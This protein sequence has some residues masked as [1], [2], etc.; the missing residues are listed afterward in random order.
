[1]ADQRDEPESKPPRVWICYAHDPPEHKVQVEEFAK[2]LRQQIGV[3]V[4]L[5][6]WYLEKRL[7][8]AQWAI[9][10]LDEADFVLVMASPKFRERADGRGSPTDGRGS[11]FEAA[12]M[13]E[14][15]TANQSL[16][17]GRILPIVLPGRS[18]DEIPDFLF[19]HSAT[20]YKI[21]EFTL[22]GVAELHWVLSRSSP[23]P[24][25][26]RGPWTTPSAVGN[27]TRTQPSAAPPAT[28]PILLTSLKPANRGADIGIGSAD[29]DGM[30]FG[31]SIVYRC[32]LFA[33]AE[34]GIIEFSLGRRYRTL[35]VTVGVLEEAAD[36]NQTGQF[37]VFLDGKQC[38]QVSAR[39]DKPV[40]VRVD[41]TNA[42]R[43]KLVA[44]RVGMTVSPLLAGARIA[45]GKPNNLPE[46]AWGNPRLFE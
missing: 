6:A 41:V 13:R 43:L 1:M 32:D 39:H 35:E 31:D 23:N 34:R 42:L 46:L 16:W 15:M 8:W 25:P 2:F 33:S 22:N 27:P 40:E 38:A 4:H 10:Q 7:D 26:K 18:V 19:P 45:G 28:A 20:Y 12:M 5:D 37:Q 24:L 17:I 29:I 44:Y 11:R 14:K 36:A 30:H 9:N 3:D 21:P